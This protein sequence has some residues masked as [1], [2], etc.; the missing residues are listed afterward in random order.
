MNKAAAN[1]LLKTLEEPAGKVVFFLISHQQYVLPATIVS[2]CQKLIFPMCPSDLARTWLADQL[3]TSESVDIWLRFAE[4]APL[5]AL[6]FARNN[7]ITIRDRVIEQLLRINQQQ[8]TAISG[9]SDLLKFD[10]DQLL[11]A[12]FLCVTDIS[13]LQ[14]GVGPVNIVNN[15][16]IP[17]LQL[18]ASQLN[19]IKLQD[20]LTRLLTIRRQLSVVSGLNQQLLI[21]DLLMMIC[22]LT[23]SEI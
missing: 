17:Q 11:Y 9:V 20:V 4:N 16:R 1:A 19:P 7:V 21:E 15:D 6:D 23:P 8:L 13:R 3:G 12:F 2:R 14:L 5:R 10:L 18:L 22:K